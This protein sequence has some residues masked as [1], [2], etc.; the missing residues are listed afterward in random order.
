MFKRKLSG[1]NR[2][3]KEFLKCNIIWIGLETEKT[4]NEPIVICFQSQEQGVC[5]GSGGGGRGLTQE[6]KAKPEAGLKNNTIV[7]NV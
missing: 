2:P 5:Q 1:N 6:G 3:E 4:V 7:F